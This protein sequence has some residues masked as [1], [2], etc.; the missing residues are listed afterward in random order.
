MSEQT[1]YYSIVLLSIN[2]QS[3][4]IVNA[5]YVLYHSGYMTIC[6]PQHIWV[7]YRM[8]RNVACIYEVLDIGVDNI[9]GIVTFNSIMWE[10]LKVVV[11][12]PT[13]LLKK[14]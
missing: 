2:R 10:H 12:L 8:G 3:H 13:S 11:C 5:F 4:T 7:I 1:P 6:I 14:R 9:G